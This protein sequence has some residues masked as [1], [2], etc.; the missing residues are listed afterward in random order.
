MLWKHEPNHLAD[1]ASMP[2]LH[3]TADHLPEPILQPLRTI[4]RQSFRH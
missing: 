1:Q 4:G 2:E 3:L